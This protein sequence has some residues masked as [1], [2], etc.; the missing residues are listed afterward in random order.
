MKIQWID[1]PTERTTAATDALI[2]VLTAGAALSLYASYAQGPH[3]FKVGVWTAAF[4]LLAAASL[5]GALAHGF[6]M[7]AK[8]YRLFWQPLNLALGLVIALFAVGVIYD[9]WGQAAAR[10]AL[11]FLLGVGVVFYAITVFKA[12]TFLVF[13]AYEAAA[14]LFALF[15]YGYLGLQGSLPGAWLMTAG[16]LVTIIAAGIQAAG[17]AR[18]T[19]VWQFDHNGVFHLVQMPGILLLWVGLA[20]ALGG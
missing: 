11:P 3:P 12:G 9:L 17:R 15:G 5:L 19:F 1:S 4:G 13:I 7:S 10:T 20:Q 8:T 16:V 14:M 18:L 2:A 6:K